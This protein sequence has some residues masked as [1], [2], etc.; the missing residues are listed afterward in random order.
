MNIYSCVA[1]GLHQ[2]AAD[3]DGSIKIKM[4]LGTLLDNK[5]CQ[6]SATMNTRV[7]ADIQIVSPIR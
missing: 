1:I 6:M 4:K 2:S 7:I 5:L 3:I